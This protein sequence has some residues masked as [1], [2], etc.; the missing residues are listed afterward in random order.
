MRCPKCRTLILAPAG[1]AVPAGRLMHCPRC[2]AAWVVRGEP[3]GVSSQ[4]PLTRRSP[5]II[6]TD[7]AAAS[8]PASVRRWR[9][10]VRRPG[11]LAAAVLALLEGA[12]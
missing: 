3:R 7:A 2:P 9:F 8:R 6:E 1:E 11:V 5:L 12:R 4:P 10:A